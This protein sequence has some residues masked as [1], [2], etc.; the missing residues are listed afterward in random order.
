MK[1]NILT[2][3]EIE[4][5]TSEERLDNIKKLKDYQKLYYEVKE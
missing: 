3:V 4:D 2:D 5:M 1:N